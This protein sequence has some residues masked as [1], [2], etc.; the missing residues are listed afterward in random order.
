MNPLLTIDMNPISNYH[1]WLQAF[2]APSDSDTKEGLLHKGFE[3]SLGKAD[4][5]EPEYTEAD[6]IIFYLSIADGWEDGSNLLRGEEIKLYP[7]S[8]PKM[9]AIRM[10]LAKKAISVLYQNSF[11]VWVDRGDDRYVYYE[12][13][14][15]SRELLPI[16]MYFFSK[17][18]KDK[19]LAP[20][21]GV[22]SYPTSSHLSEQLAKFLIMLIQ[23]ILFWDADDLLAGREYS[24]MAPAEKLVFGELVD[25]ETERFFK[26][27]VWAVEMLSSLHK[28]DVLEKGCMARS[29]IDDTVVYALQAIELRETIV[30]KGETMKVKNHHQALKAGSKAAWI[31]AKHYVENDCHPQAPKPVRY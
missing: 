3:K 11:K 20:R 24:R 25:T 9:Q 14:V 30:I 28:L 15:T 18:Q 19:T 6:R 2:I 21:N 23:A 12:K 5:S 8:T 22:H 13:M 26:A 4:Y 16:L 17:E 7:Q 1:A 29:F 27:K 10:S 31:L